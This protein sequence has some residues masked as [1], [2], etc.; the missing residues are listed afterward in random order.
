MGPAQEA[1]LAASAPATPSA[2]PTEGKVGA[3]RKSTPDQASIPAWIL[4][5]WVADEGGGPHVLGERD[6]GLEHDSGSIPPLVRIGEP[7]RTISSTPIKTPV[8][9]L[10][11]PATLCA[12]P[13]DH[14]WRNA[15]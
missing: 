11:M 13:G 2:S 6:I 7:L 10:R 9:C 4:W 1:T 8:Y 14:P 3:Y 15:G 5:Y 12:P